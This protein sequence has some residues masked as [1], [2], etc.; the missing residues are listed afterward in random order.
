MAEDTLTL[1]FHVRVSDYRQE[2][3]SV[4]GEIIETQKVNITS[5]GKNSN[6]TG[7]VTPCRH[8]DV[9]LSGDSFVTGDF[10]PVIGVPFGSAMY[11]HYH[12]Y[13]CKG[14]KVTAESLAS[15]YISIGELSHPAVIN[16]DG[17]VSYLFSE[18]DYKTLVKGP[19]YDTVLSVVDSQGNRSIV[20]KQLL[21]L[22]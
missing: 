7:R 8:F 11:L 12:L 21:R 15:S 22:V 13:D 3:S 9:P 1:S 18:N 2:Q 14:S 4:S 20:S 6:D 10:K 17:T 5:S 16:D 19:I